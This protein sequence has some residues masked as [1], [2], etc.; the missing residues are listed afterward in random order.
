MQAFDRPG[1]LGTPKPRS[2]W[3]F[4]ERLKMLSWEYCWACFCSWTPKPLNRWRLFWLRL[5]GA[6]VHGVPFVHQR[7]R[8]Q[9][10]WN[11]TFHDMSC[12]GDRTNL[13]SLGPIEIGE[14]AVI[15]QEAY[16]CTGSHRFD[17]PGLPLTVEK[18][19]IGARAFIGAR[20]FI[21]PGVTIGHGAIV[22]AGAVV[23]RDV[24][25]H[26]INAGNPCKRIGSRPLPH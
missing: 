14:G 25:A 16:L 3:T 21:L 7:A 2:P 24:D 6:K 1:S 18:I 13:Y 4:K 12:V 19:T 23:S 9:V 22:G 20:V 17:E 11:I 5:Y 10:P 15:A 26:S 8:I